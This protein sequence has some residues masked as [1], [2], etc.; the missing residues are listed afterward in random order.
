MKAPHPAV[1]PSS[2][3]AYSSSDV[4]RSVRADLAGLP[5]EVRKELMSPAERAADVG[6]GDAAAAVADAVIAEC[7][8]GAIAGSAG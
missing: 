8:D 2:S 7:A 1:R 3:S 4:S 6:S 5:S